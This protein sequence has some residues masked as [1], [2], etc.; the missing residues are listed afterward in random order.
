MN[1][2]YT[3]FES[4]QKKIGVVGLGYVGLPLAI[5]FGQYFKVVGVDI[6]QHKIDTL[7]SGTDPNGEVDASHITT[8]DISFTTDARALKECAVIVVAVPTPVDESKKPDLSPVTGACKMVG[9]NLSTGSVVVFESTVYPGVTEDICAPILAA[10]SNLKWHKDFKIGY[11]PERL[12]PGDKEHTL[13]KIVKVV[14]GEDAD[15]LELLAQLYGK[16]VP[17]GIHRAS[18]IK[19][20]EAAKV[21]ENAQRDVNIAFMNELA[22]IFNK[23]N[24][25]TNEVLAAAST[26]WNFI[27]FSPGLVGGHCIG[28]DPYYLTYKAET[29]GYHPQVILAGRRINDEMGRYIAQQTIKLLIKAGKS[30]STANVLVMGLTFKENVSD[31]RNTRVIDIISELKEFGANV[32]VHDPLVSAAEAKH[33]FDIELSSLTEIPKIDAIVVSAAH[34]PFTELKATDFEALGA[35]SRNVLVDVKSV[36][37]SDNRPSHWLYWSL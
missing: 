37:Q 34:R 15:T 22:I 12:N 35:S 11:S 36:I 10:E 23:M 16:I 30:V 5:E 7:N 27:K 13:P 20:A 8:A 9:K 21:I 19:V 28:V 2:K 4:K 33:E 24:I 18:S 3:D 25:P 26:K 31:I 1:L 6:S 32:F 29:L 14:S 17:A